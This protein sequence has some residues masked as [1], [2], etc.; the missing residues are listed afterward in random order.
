MKTE[1]LS[2]LLSFTIQKRQNLT[3]R[4]DRNLKWQLFFIILG[5]SIL[6]NY[7][8]IVEPNLKEYLHVGYQTISPI[9]PIFLLIYY[10][11]FGYMLGL[12]YHNTKAVK[13]LIEKLSKGL[14]FKEKIMIAHMSSEFSLLEPFTN[15]TVLAKSG[16]PLKYVYFIVLMSFLITNHYLIFR[17]IENTVLDQ[18]SHWIQLILT[19]FFGLLLYNFSTINHKEKS[20][21]IL[22]II[23]LIADIGLAIYFVSGIR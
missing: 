22:S 14:D 23:M 21:M 12:H 1:K 20:I 19:C 9:I 18:Y 10:I 4:I 8:G 11:S 5:I 7:K 2:T 17:F 15:D 3:K 13:M 6:S 16:K